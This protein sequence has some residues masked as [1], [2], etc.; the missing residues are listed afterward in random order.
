MLTG[1]GEP[2]LTYGYPLGQSTL[3]VQM[4]AFGLENLQLFVTAAFEAQS[5]TRAA[6]DQ[7]KLAQDHTHLVLV[8]FSQIMSMPRLSDDAAC[9]SS[10]ERGSAEQRTKPRQTTEPHSKFTKAF[11]IPK[12]SEHRGTL[13][14]VPALA[15]QM[16]PASHAWS[17]TMADGPP[18]SLCHP[19]I[20]IDR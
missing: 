10:P 8:A 4:H 20:H 6:G 17:G 19:V 7:R 2:G 13:G 12:K 11:A 5:T 16:V 1:P 9:Q 18:P 3:F 14:P 15:P